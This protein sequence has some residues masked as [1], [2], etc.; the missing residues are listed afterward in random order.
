MSLVLIIFSC[1]QYIEK[2]LSHSEV[3]KAHIIVCTY[4]LYARLVTSACC[5]QSNNKDAE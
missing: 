2:S 1:S 4:L 5:L 3:K